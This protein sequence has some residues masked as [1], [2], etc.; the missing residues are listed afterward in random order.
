MLGKFFLQIMMA[1]S[2]YSL[3][4]LKHACLQFFNN[5]QD[6]RSCNSSPLD[7]SRDQKETCKVKNAEIL[8]YI[9]T[10]NVKMLSE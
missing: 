1:I 9:L 6:L 7:S 4:F 8:C 3:M 10:N 2:L 5:K